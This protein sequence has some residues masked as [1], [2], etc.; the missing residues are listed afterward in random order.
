MSGTIPDFS[1]PLLKKLILKNN[2]LSGTLPHDLGQ[3]HERLTTFDVMHN[4]ITGPIPESIK[5]LEN[6]DTFSLSE[7]DFTGVSF[8]F[9]FCVNAD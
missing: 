9:K 8:I 5:V 6:L 7:N 3:R 2:R 4:Y 1:S